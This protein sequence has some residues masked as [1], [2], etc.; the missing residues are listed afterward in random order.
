MKFFA[1][2]LATAFCATLIAGTAA[3]AQAVHVDYDHSIDFAK[4]KS[5]T[6]Q[7]VHATEP[8]VEEAITIAVDRD[9]ANRYLHP[10]SKNGDLILAVVEANQDKQEYAKFYD[11]LGGLNW[12]RGWGS[13]G[14]MDSAATVQDI[15]A[16]TLV[17]NMWDR[18]TQKLVWRGTIAE[19]LTG[20]K[21]KNDQKM[22]K[23][24]GQLVSQF[25]PKF[26]K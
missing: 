19:N 5:Y 15:P 17:L 9:L 7:E 2:M 4:Y 21:D 16:G 24:V 12:Q 23:A 14:F 22:D 26:K 10:D 13:G 3:M 20:N 8:N 11:G 18:K 1:K 25:P 6:L